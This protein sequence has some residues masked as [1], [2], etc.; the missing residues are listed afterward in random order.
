[1]KIGKSH[2][3]KFA[4]LLGLLL[5]LSV[6]SIYL[7]PSRLSF[8]MDRAKLLH[9]IL[10]IR[11]P[12]I[13]IAIA[14]GMALSLAGAIMQTILGNPLASPFTLGVS[15]AAAFG[16]SLAIVI[17]LSRG[18][19]WIRPGIFSFLFATVSVLVLVFLTSASG[20][21][22]KNII[23]VGMAINFFFNAATTILQ[24]YASPDAVFQMTIWSAGSL[25]GATVQDAL[26]LFAVL[27]AAL[28]VSFLFSGDLGLIQ[29]G[30]RVAVMHGVP[31][32]FERVLF[33]LMSSLLA[34]ASVS[35]IGIIGFVGLVSP[36]VAR[37]LGFESPESLFLGSIAVGPLFMVIADIVSK[38]VR[39]P[40]ILPISAVTSFIGI[41]CLL[42]L[43]F[44]MRRKQ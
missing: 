25:T 28:S 32:N 26:I 42:L 33:L 18:I 13:L 29:Q 21:S 38:T 14:S 24:Y 34:S 15:S 22:K 36:H 8:S 31:V 4:L 40:T 5:V 43:V 1:M 30:E 41:P 44:C 20:I 39:Y 9:I 23:L 12:E 27:A 7:F 10:K 2:L 16:S 17:S 6:F 11:L 35:I 19:A 3:I 37:L